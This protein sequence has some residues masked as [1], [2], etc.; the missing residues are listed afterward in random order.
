M[1]SIGYVS[2]SF[3]QSYTVHLKSNCNAY[4]KTITDDDFRG[5]SISLVSIFEHCIY[6][7]NGALYESADNQFGF[8]NAN[9]VY[10]LRSVVDHYVSF[11]ITLNICAVDLSKAFDKMNHLF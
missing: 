10:V 1:I 7:R 9:A 2:L 5:V 11:G 8:K 4:G 3:G 6:D